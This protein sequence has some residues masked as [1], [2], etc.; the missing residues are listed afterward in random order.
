MLVLNEL[1]LLLLGAV[2][3]PGVAPRVFEKFD[4]LGDRGNLLLTMLP[5]ALGVTLRE[6][7][8]CSREI[9]FYL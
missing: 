8:Y 7:L 4:K 1:R 5:S 6:Y 3:A 9:V 2:V